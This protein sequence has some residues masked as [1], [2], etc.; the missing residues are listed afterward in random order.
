MG[1]LVDATVELN[2]EEVLNIVNESLKKG[3]DPLQILQELQKGVELVGEKY[4]RQEYFLFNLIWAGEIFKEAAKVLLPKIQESY[5]SIKKKGKVLIGTVK[6][7][8]HD[9]GKNIVI[10][11]LESAGYEVVDLGVDVPPEEF[12]KKAKEVKPDVIAM[13]GLLTASVDAMDENTQRLRKEGIKAKIIVGGG[14]VG[15]EYV[16]GKLHVDATATSAPDGIKKIEKLM[17]ES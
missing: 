2:K 15:E 11:L 7:D 9:I 1:K 12:A 4:E 5:K 17:A 8:I 14:I 16:K 13:S 10:T 6:G 3:Q